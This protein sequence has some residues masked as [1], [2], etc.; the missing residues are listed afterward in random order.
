MNRS[1]A[2]EP[3][4]EESCPESDFPSELTRKAAQQYQGT[5]KAGA[6]AARISGLGTDRREKRCIIEA[7]DIAGITAG[8]SVLDCPCGAG[9]LI[10][11]LKKFGF[12]VTGADISASM[13]ELARQHAGPQGENCL[14]EK[15]RFCVTNLFHSGFEDGQFDGVVCHR[16]FQYFSE[17]GERL[18]ALRE[19]RRISSG[20]VI[21]S[22]LCNWSIDALWRSIRSAL[23]L[24]RLRKCPPISPLTFAKEIRSAG[25]RIKCWIAMRPFLSRR[26]YVVLEP[27]SLLQE[28]ILNSVLAYRRIILSAGKRVAVCVLAVLLPLFAYSLVMNSPSRRLHEI[29]SLAMQHQDGDDVFYVTRS[30]GTSEPVGKDIRLTDIKRIDEDIVSTEKSGKDPFF[31][32]SGEEM[33]E[34]RSSPVA[35]RLEFV[36]RARLGTKRFYLLRMPDLD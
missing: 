33:R 11:I 16:I 31:L 17:P 5:I 12:T 14:D 2:D 19:L 1:E 4:F 21:V 22:F 8:S 25:F 24:A 32:L 20:P 7:L 23:G 9:R 36:A 29:E 28:G 18:L 35:R 13:V 15:D 34:V 26:W 3:D 30:S 10:P 6:Y 27:A